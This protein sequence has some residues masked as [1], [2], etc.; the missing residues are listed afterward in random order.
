MRANYLQYGSS[1]ARNCEQVKD[2]TDSEAAD[3]LLS[4]CE[5]AKHTSGMPLSLEVVLL[6]SFEDHLAR[7]EALEIA[8]TILLDRLLSLLTHR[9]VQL[10]SK[11]VKGRE[12]IS[13]DRFLSKGSIRDVG[14][15]MPSIGFRTAT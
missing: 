15:V 3:S 1:A 13:D 9:D 5:P 4:S 10:R 7:V 6:P 8:R 2:V 11:D 12:I 14:S